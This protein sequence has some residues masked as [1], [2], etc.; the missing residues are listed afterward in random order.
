MERKRYLELCQKYA[1]VE[2]TEVLY[3]DTK[4]HP[5]AYELSFDKSG[6]SIHRAILKDKNANSLVYCKLEEVFENENKS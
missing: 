3:K 4:Y 5:K 1:V 2:D 6:S